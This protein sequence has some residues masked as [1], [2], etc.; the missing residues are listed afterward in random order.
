MGTLKLYNNGKMIYT[1]L[2]LDS[3]YPHPETGDNTKYMFCVYTDLLNPNA[4][5]A[6][7]LSRSSSLSLWNRRNSSVTSDSL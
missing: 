5:L 7:S 3:G 4:L 6:R 1:L 2:W